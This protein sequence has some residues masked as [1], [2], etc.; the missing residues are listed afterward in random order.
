VSGVMTVELVPGRE[1]GE[2]MSCAL[3]STSARSPTFLF[4]EE[5]R[6][7]VERS[8]LPSASPAAATPTVLEATSCKISAY[9]FQTRSIPPEI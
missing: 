3:P 6:T 2:D 4:L 5:G 7:G 1:T 8:G 9:A